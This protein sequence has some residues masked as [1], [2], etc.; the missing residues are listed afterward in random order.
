MVE[1]VEV[2]DRDKVEVIFKFR[3]EYEALSSYAGVM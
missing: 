2:H 3:D 1:R